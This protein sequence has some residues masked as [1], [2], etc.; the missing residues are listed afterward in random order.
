[1][2]KIESDLELVEFK[3]LLPHVSNQR[4][5]DA[6]IKVAPGSMELIGLEKLKK[7]LRENPYT[8]AE[9]PDCGLYR[10]DDLKRKIGATDEGLESALRALSA[11]EIKVSARAIDVL[12]FTAV[13]GKAIHIMYFHRDP[14]VRKSG[15]ANIFI[16]NLDKSIDSKALHNTFCSFSNILSCKIATDGTGQSKGLQVCAV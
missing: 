10:W 16:K 13:N 12:N 8:S 6:V 5:K 3:K 11:V 15:I 1:M 7:L 14:S 2:G 4:L 9:M